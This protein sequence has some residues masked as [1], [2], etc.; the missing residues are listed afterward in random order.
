M[1]NSDADSRGAQ[2]H[3]VY[4]ECAR[5]ICQYNKKSRDFDKSA[6]HASFEQKHIDKYKYI[7]Y[8]Y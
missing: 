4:T 6:C 5:N 3:K 2:T 1:R 8:T 7:D